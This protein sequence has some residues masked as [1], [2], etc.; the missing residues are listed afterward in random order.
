MTKL[1]IIFFFRPCNAFSAVWC[2][3]AH[4]GGALSLSH[5][6]A[7]QWEVLAWEKTPH[8]CSQWETSDELYLSLGTAPQDSF[9]QGPVF[10]CAVHT[11]GCCVE[12][13]LGVP[14]LAPG[15]PFLACRFSFWRVWWLYLVSFRD[16]A[17]AVSR[18]HCSVQ[19]LLSF[20][21][22]CNSLLCPQSRS[23][24]LL[25]ATKANFSPPTPAGNE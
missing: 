10:F 3:I 22:N 5:S 9:S 13:S 4:P 19:C 2:L 24:S 8:S 16:L 21:A 17:W 1:E 14:S 7:A 18:P 12:A 6:Q 11:F 23:L 15:T 25:L 20:R